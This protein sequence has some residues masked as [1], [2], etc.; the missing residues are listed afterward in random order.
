MLDMH[1]KRLRAIARFSQLRNSVVVFDTINVARSLALLALTFSS[2]ARDVHFLRA[3]GR[4][5]VGDIAQRHDDSIRATL[6]V[7]F[8][9]AGLP[10]DDILM[11]DVPETEATA[12]FLESYP[13]LVLP[14]CLPVLY[15]ISFM[16]LED[17]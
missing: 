6:A 8:G 15:C 13:R 16:D 14:R 4:R 7:V 12:A 3:L 11:A 17:V 2:N 9:Q 10:A 5:W 1:D